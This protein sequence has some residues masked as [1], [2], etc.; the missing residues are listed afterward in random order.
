MRKFPQNRELI[1]DEESWEHDNL[2]FR[3]HLANPNSPYYIEESDIVP[4]A[5][6]VVE[7]IH[8]AGGKA[9]L[10]HIY[11]Y[12]ENAEKIITGL[13]DIIDGI[14]CF[15]PSYTME[16][17]EYLVKLC[18]ENSL[19]ATGGSDYHGAKRTNALG[20]TVLPSHY[21]ERLGQLHVSEG[22]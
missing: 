7:I 14:E 1:P 17:T 12:N 3:N 16:Q 6:K 13:L 11:Q 19:I 18:E 20:G 22:K 9:V 5:E 10:P 21:R 4:P 8:K 2:F 15:Y